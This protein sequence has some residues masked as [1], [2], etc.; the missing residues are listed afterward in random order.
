MKKGI[1]VIAFI[2]VTGLSGLFAQQYVVNPIPSFNY[3]LTTQSTTFRER[4]GGTN[5]REKREMDVVISSSST[6]SFPVYA[7]VWIKKVNSQVV[8]GPYIIFLDEPLTVQIDNSK[9]SA[10]IECAWGVNASV[11]IE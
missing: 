3:A 5:N 10:V 9:W 8:L 4:V 11:W 6:N 2:L 1:L 7:T